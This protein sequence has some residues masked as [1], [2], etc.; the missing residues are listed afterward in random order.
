MSQYQHIVRPDC[1]VP[2]GTIVIAYCRDSGGDDQDRS[3]AQQMATIREYCIRHRL[4][5]ETIYVDEAKKSSNTEKRDAL[6]DLLANIRDRFP[7]IHNQARRHRMTASHPA[8]LLWRS[9]RIGR[10]AVECSYLTAE[11]QM[12]ALT[13]F[14]L[15]DA[16][17]TG[18]AALDGVIASVQRMHDQRVLS[19]ISADSRRGLAHLVGMCD[20]DMSFI[21]HNPDWP[22]RDG[23]Y[24]GLMPGHP[25]TGFIGERVIIG[26]NRRGEKREVQR[27]APDPAK[28]DSVVLAW[29]LR[30]AGASIKTIHNSTRLF[31]TTNGYTTFFRNRIYA[32]D[33]EYGGQRYIDFVPAAVSRED[34]E[35][36]QARIAARAIFDTGNSPRARGSRHLLSG[37]V[38]C[39]HVQGQ[40]HPM[41]ASTCRPREGRNAWDY[42]MCTRRKNTRG[43]GCSMT[44]INARA[45][46][47]SVV[48]F[49]MEEILTFESLKSLSSQMSHALVDGSSDAKIQ[50][51][52]LERTQEKTRRAI[53]FLMDAIEQGGASSD[54]FLRLRKRQNELA[55]LNSD[56]LAQQQRIQDADTL[57]FPSDERIKDWLLS[58]RAALE[59][60]DVETARAVVRMLVGKVVMETKQKATV[61]YRSPLFPDM[62]SLESVT[63]TG[64]EPVQPP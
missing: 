25:P 1:P 62:S 19:D 55:T 22:T 32:G 38:M 26:V 16:M 8:I 23:R 59:G 39:G 34:F 4:I 28:W 36:E 35:S 18:D 31:K 15:V 63:P 60:E 51:A 44:R 50:L 47:K 11:F 57:M 7:T 3:I 56:I 2:A 30:C 14:G 17:E 29:K 5:L 12:R 53:E 61:W 46:T 43:E 33:L 24:L 45:L 52:T 49:L 41:N 40:E 9:N 6:N 54:I 64:L 27:L 48:D 10:D 13:V 21:I 20:T 37:L 58:T 42:Y